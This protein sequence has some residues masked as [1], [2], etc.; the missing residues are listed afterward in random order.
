VKSLRAANLRNGIDDLKHPKLAEDIP[1]TGTTDSQADKIIAIGRAAG[2]GCRSG[3]LLGGGSCVAGAH[4]GVISSSGCWLHGGRFGLGAGRV[5]VVDRGA[6]I[7]H[8]ALDG[9]AMR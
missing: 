7:N 3:W 6:A 2:E 5:S 9:L 8:P 1:L 4:Q